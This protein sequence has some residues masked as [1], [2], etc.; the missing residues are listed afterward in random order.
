MTPDVQAAL[1]AELH[2][3]EGT[4]L[5]VYDDATGKPIGPGTVVKG[6]PSIGTGRNLFARGI[7]YAES[8]MLLSNDEACCEA[9]LVPLLPW[10]PTLSANRQ[11][12][13]YS[14]YF[15]TSV[16]DRHRF[17]AGWPHFLAQMGAQQFAA[18]A[19]NLQSS[20]PWATQVGP[21]ALRLA[22]LIRNG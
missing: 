12:A 1:R 16:G 19:D 5:F 10:L 20:Q 13:V 2:G 11:A 18:A 17:V 15:N 8:E 21:R 4:K 14:L 22:N 9:D 3:D 6:N 7:S